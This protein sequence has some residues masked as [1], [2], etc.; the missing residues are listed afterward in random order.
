[1]LNR[2]TAPFGVFWEASGWAASFRMRKLQLN[3]KGVM[4]TGLRG[5]RQY[6]F[7]LNPHSMSEKIIPQ[8]N[9]CNLRVNHEI[10]MFIYHFW[11]IF[12]VRMHFYIPTGGW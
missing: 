3:I 4:R 5:G 6:I 7:V 12:I 11:R 8:K 9:T 2:N 10:K 1:M